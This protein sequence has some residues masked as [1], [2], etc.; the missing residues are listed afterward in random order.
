[1]GRARTQGPARGKGAERARRALAARLAERR[2]EIEQAALTRVYAVQDPSESDPTYLQGLR[3]AVSA[4]LTY[5]LEA[6]ERG[7]GHAPP[8][9]VALLAQART[10]ARSGVS[11]DT[12]LR[13][14][15][16]GYT[17]LGDFLSEEA[18]AV[19][20]LEGTALSHLLREQATLFDRLIAAISDE[21][22]REAQSS[23]V[24]GPQQ[25]RAGQVERLL[26]AEPVDS[27]ELPYAFEGFHLGLLASG[28]AAPEAVREVAARLDRCLLMLE[29]EDGTLWAWLGSRRSLDTTELVDLLAS[30]WPARTPL[31]LGEPGEGIAGWRL[32]HRQARAALPVALRSSNAFARYADVAFLA[33]ALQYDLLGTSLRQLY[34]APL[35]HDRD[36]GHVARH[37]LRAYF[38][39]EQNVS[40]TAAVLGVS[41]Q[42]V[43]S[44][45]R[46]IEERLGQQIS[47]CVGPLETV[48]RM[49]ELGE[50]IFGDSNA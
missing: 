32:T 30:A 49:D 10:A 1:M 20:S 23:L 50:L 43:N 36:G 48:L 15:F 13:R 22:G 4:A 6:I 47:E 5:G 33:S 26:A 37:T 8:V 28:A 40:S 9:P 14:Y 21:Y 18:A 2:G 42:A 44:R 3:E 24:A 29:R 16:A 31:A 41:R 11:L 38:A 19:D 34:L 17:L 25:R 7:E 27:S 35:E 39:A 46:A 45:L 12:V